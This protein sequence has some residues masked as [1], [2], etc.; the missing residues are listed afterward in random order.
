MRE[1]VIKAILDSGDDFISG[2]QLS[3]ELGISRTAVWK[4]IKALKEEGYNIES[5]NRKGYRL[6]E[7]PDDILS[8]QNITHNLP[9]EF[10]GKKVIHFETIGSTN[11]YAKEIG[12]KVDQGTLIISEEQTKGKGRLGRIWKSVPGEGIWMSLIDRKSVV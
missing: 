11:D 2:E 7:K 4:H 6:A 5:V 8:E 9:T 12:N 1:K 10:I 3:K